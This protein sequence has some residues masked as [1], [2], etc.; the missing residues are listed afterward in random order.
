MTT[1]IEYMRINHR[2]LQ[3]I[4]PQKSLNGANIGAALQ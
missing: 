1:L 4:V 2:C 3:V